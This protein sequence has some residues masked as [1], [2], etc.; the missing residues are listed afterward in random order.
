MLQSSPKKETVM[1][2]QKFA[3]NWVENREACCIYVDC[4]NV[5]FVLPA[6]IKE[7]AQFLEELDVVDSHRV[8]K[9]VF[10]A[11]SIASAVLRKLL[12]IK[13]PSVPYEIFTDA[14]KAWD[15]VSQ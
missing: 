12:E 2:C 15:Y 7:Q 4:S 11:G 14:D 9:V 5:S 13:A 10:V 8:K 3:R 1:V 6:V